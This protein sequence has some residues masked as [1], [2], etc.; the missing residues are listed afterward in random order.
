[1]PSGARKLYKVPMPKARDGRPRKLSEPLTEE[2]KPVKDPKQ[3]RQKI[4][5]SV[6]A[7]ST[8]FE[9]NRRRH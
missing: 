3:T 6:R 4:T 2:P 9:S 1:M 7:I 8:A 5:G